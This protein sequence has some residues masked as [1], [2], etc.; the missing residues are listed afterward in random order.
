M[1]KAIAGIA[2]MLLLAGAGVAGAAEH[3]VKVLNQGQAGKMVFEPDLLRVAV[4]DT[5]LFKMIDAH[6]FVGSVRNM[7]PPGAKALRG[8][9]SKDYKVTF[10]VPGIYGYECFVHIH[11]YGMAGVIVVGNDTSNMAAAKAALAQTPARER[12]RLEALLKQLG[13]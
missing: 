13:G 7:V 5:V 6:H 4:G 8:E 10:T 1:N 9:A 3:E 2:G 12:E 11:T